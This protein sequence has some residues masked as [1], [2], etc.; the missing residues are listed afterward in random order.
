MLISQLYFHLIPCI[1]DLHHFRLVGIDLSIDQ[2]SS[3]YFKCTQPHAKAVGILYSTSSG[4]RCSLPLGV[5]GIR[6]KKITHGSIMGNFLLSVNRPKIQCQYQQPI[7]YW[8]SSALITFAPR[9]WSGPASEWM[10]W[11]RRGHR[12]SCR[13]WWR[14]GRGSQ[15]SLCST[16]R[17]SKIKFHITPFFL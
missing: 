12:R 17:P 3:C 14:R 8:Y 6:P 16:S 9:T 4:E 10:D 2:A 1:D 15:R 5:L 7:V 11:D 13:Q